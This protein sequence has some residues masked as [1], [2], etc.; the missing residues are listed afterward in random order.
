MAIKRIDGEW[1][2]KTSEGWIWMPCLHAA[3]SF[4]KEVKL[5]SR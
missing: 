3:I 4:A 2:T 1:Y 5:E